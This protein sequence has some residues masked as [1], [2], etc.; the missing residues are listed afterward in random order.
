MTATPRAYD[1]AGS[2]G[3]Q[4]AMAFLNPKQ[5]WS[6]LQRRRV[7]RAVLYY[8]AG[9]WV[10]A[11]VIDLLLDAFDA[12]HYMRYAVAALVLG[13][14]VAALL[15]WIFDFKLSGI[16]R[17]PPLPVPAIDPPD[18]SIAVLPFANLSHEVE[19]EYFSDGLAEEIRN[20]LARVRGLRVAARSSSFAFKG[21]HEDVREIGRRLNVAAVLEGGV[22][23]QGGTV[24]IDVQL[25]SARD[26]YQVWSETFERNLDDIFKLQTEVACAV[27]SAIRPRATAERLPT[28]SATADFEAYNLYLLGR[29]HFHKRNESALRRAIDCFQRAIAHDPDYALAYSGLA[30]AYS[31]AS[32]GYYGELPVT[33]SL[34]HALPAALKAIELAPMLAEAHASLGL[35][36]HNQGDP[37]TAESA[38]ARAIELNPAYPMAHVWRGL[39]L[40]SMGRYRE[41]AA[42][43]REAFRL[44][45][46]SP[47]INANVGFDAL[48]FGDVA[49]AET[50]FRTAIEIDPAFQVPY[51][52]M[53]RLNMARGATEDALRWIEQAIDRAPARAFYIARKGLILAQLGRTDAAVAIVDT[54]CCNPTANRFEAD[55]V[56]GL[57][58]ASA[59]RAALAATAAHPGGSIWAAAQRA[60]ALIAV[61]DAPAALRAYAEAP[62]DP[63]GA[64]NDLVNDEWVWRLPHVVNHAHLRKDA[65]DGQWHDALL[66]VVSRADELQAVGVVNVDVLYLVASAHAVMGEREWALAVLE[67]A[68]ELGWRHAWW[69]R[70]DWNWSSLREDPRFNE[71]LA[72]AQPG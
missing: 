14:P 10:L 44:D 56:V 64:V 29:H 52:G 68:V 41:A 20:Q 33:E 22:R 43:M 8:V 63:R 60:Q 66:A 27:I 62:P 42:S 58:I 70:H 19:N 2:L 65:G 51:S 11:Q 36:R 16:E 30:D 31:L 24:R 40:T 4:Q 12:S 47:I 39:I 23:K 72:R 28:E 67:Q 54:A 34:A 7:V 1:G 6:E 17:T 15:A 9:A 37:A 26:G 38:M 48:R 57:R 25:V 53:T 49:E 69:A 32:T 61:G 50:R 13:L 59:D 55:L 35:V 21:R 45:P 71:L 3:A 18:D 5:L 46:L